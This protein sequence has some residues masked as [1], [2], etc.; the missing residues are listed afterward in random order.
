MV[1]G[2]MVT[3]IMITVTVARRHCPLARSARPPPCCSTDRQSRTPLGVEYRELA[4]GA[5]HAGREAANDAYAHAHRLC[6]EHRLPDTKRRRHAG[7]PLA[8]LSARIEQMPRISPGRPN[9]A[10]P[11][12]AG[13]FAA[14]RFDSPRA[15]KLSRGP[16]VAGCRRLQRELPPATGADIQSVCYA[17]PGGRSLFWPGGALPFPE[18]VVIWDAPWGWPPGFE[19]CNAPPVT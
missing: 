12:C 18:V 17:R 16:R 5:E 19:L 11:C 14:R 2:I 1:T 6:G 9:R 3:G 8:P 4:L 13:V 15:V 7:I 10:R